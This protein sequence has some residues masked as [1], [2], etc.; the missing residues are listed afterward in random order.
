MKLWV[1][2]L[3]LLLLPALWASESQEQE[4]KD[5]EESTQ[6][7]PAAQPP[8]CPPPS[9]RAV[10]PPPPAASTCD[11]CGGLSQRARSTSHAL[12]SGLGTGVCGPCATPRRC[13]APRPLVPQQRRWGRCGASDMLTGSTCWGWAAVR[14]DMI[15]PAGYC[16]PRRLLRPT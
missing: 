4:T 11:A 1:L 5:T 3:L 12:R 8:R 10:R 2:L 13:R 16:T 14:A 7:W 9:C 15:P 6:V